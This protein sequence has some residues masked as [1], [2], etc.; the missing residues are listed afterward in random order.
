MEEQGRRGDYWEWSNIFK[1]K[2]FDH[3]SGATTFNSEKMLNGGTREKRRNA[4]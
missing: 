3:I 2:S 1:Y 4:V